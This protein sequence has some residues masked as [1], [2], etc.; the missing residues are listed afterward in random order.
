[1][2]TPITLP[3]GMAITGEIK[4]GYEAILTPDALE[5]VASLHRAFEPRRQALLQARVER[6][7]RLDAGERPD[8][9]P[10][11]KA[12]REG[13]WKVAPLP[14][15]L[16]CRRVEITGPVER[17]MIINAL[18]SGADSYMTDFEDSNAPSWTNQ[19][20]GQI[21]LK[22]AVRR[23]ISLEQNGKS[24]KLN[25]KIATLIVRPRGWH[26]DEKHVTVDGQRVSGGIFDFALFLFHNARELIARGSGPYFY[27]PKMESHLEA[28]LWNDI[29]V[30]AQEAIG[31][32]RGTIRATVLIETILAAFEMDEIL[33]ELREH[34]SGL[35]AG[36]WDYIFSAIKKFKNDRDFCLADRSK[37]TMTVPFMRAYALL[38]LKTCHK[39]NAPAIGGMS[40]LIPIKNDPEANEKAMAGVRSDKQR[41]A[42]DGYDGGWVAHPGLVPIAMEEFVKVL[43][44]KPNQIGKQRD[45]VQVEG[46]NLLDF[47]PE[48]PITEAG[49]RNNINVGIHYLGAWLDGNG[50]VPIHNLMEDAAT[51]EI[52]RSQ[53]WQWIR[54]PK[55]VLD[56]GRKVTAELVREFAKAE[57]ENVKRSVGGNTQPYERAAAIF[58]QMSTSEGFTEFLTLPLYEEI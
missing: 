29:F 4:P 6:T 22:D 28:R 55:G 19:I 1:M 51:A 20:D 38:L 52:S 13:D 48:A 25:D 54:S 3:Q 34:S 31:I 14:A 40:A 58:E 26:L 7:K 15:D 23:T 49:L 21:N 53:V 33:Y 32:P 35:N 44:D 12:I 57:L 16:Q 41:D 39:R 9:L 18:N 56:D 24:Y 50:C 10:E 37:I 27:L 36:R 11:T 43:G 8:F 30:A 5:L 17:K 45:D 46:K 2:S 47:Q 42:T